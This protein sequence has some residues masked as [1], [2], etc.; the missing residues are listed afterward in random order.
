M[1]ACY[2][3]LSN[4]GH[5]SLAGTLPE[6]IQWTT[7]HYAYWV[8]FR[9][10]KTCISK[11]SLRFLN[12]FLSKISLWMIVKCRKYSRSRCVFLIKRRKLLNF[13]RKGY[14]FSERNTKACKILQA[15]VWQTSSGWCSMKW[16]LNRKLGKK[17]CHSKTF[18]NFP[19]YHKTLSVIWK[20]SEFVY[21]PVSIDY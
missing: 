8:N 19:N 2:P 7:S 3:Q 18:R 13:Y 5:Q 6:S 20:N 12:L 21:H 10:S 16:S 11:R 17:E 4:H 14:Q 9:K 15:I 1:Y